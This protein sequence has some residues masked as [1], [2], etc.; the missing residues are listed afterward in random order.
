MVDKSEKF[1]WLVRLGFA[2]RG[3]VYV[4]IGYLALTAANGDKGP[5]G[6]F[7][8][9]QDAPLGQPIL[10]A[11]SVG[12][13][14]Y[15][16]FRLCS[17]IFDV[18]HHGSD[19]KGMLHRLGHGASAIAH[20]VL[21]WTA[22]QFAHGDRQTP[23][24]GGQAHETAGSLLS[25]AFGPLLLGLLGL[26]FIAAG[27]LQAKS[28]YTG[29]FMK[30]VAGNAPS[31]VE[32]IGRAGHAARAAVF[33]II[34]WSLIQSGWLASGEQ[35]KTL[36]EAVNS[37]ADNGVLYTLVAIG[38]LLFGVFSLYIAFYRIVPDIDRRDLKP[39]FR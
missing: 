33:L 13:L 34:G 31:P 39:S 21:A 3:L 14:A 26:G 36:G 4:L 22:F 15:A 35:V 12:L 20:L 29:S 19:G 7:D 38:L 16:L 9:L 27:A 11:A 18:E 8:W 10:Y 5:E 24:G 28:A 32:P 37:L 23:S 1:S 30:R 2:A 6:A 17:L 25:F